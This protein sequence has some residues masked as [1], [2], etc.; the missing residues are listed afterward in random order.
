MSLW[1]ELLMLVILSYTVGLAGGWL[2]WKL[3]RAMN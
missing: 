2:L 3:G 1:T